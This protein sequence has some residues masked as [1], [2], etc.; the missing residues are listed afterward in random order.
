MTGP[1]QVGWGDALN[2]LNRPSEALTCY[3]QAVRLAPKE[4]AAAD[5]LARILLTRSASATDIPEAQ[6]LLLRTARQSPQVALTYLL[7]GQCYERQ[8]R[9]REARASLEEA[10]RRDPRLNEVHFEL[11]RVAQ[12]LGDAR[13]TAREQSLYQRRVTEDAQ[14]YALRLH[15]AQMKD[16]PGRTAGAGEA[17]VPE[18]AIGM[19]PFSSAARSSPNGPASSRLASN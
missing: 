19:R 9:W 12:N 13:T 1:T 5:S 4:P 17:F 15:V 14:I 10:G 2:A 7:L 16:D 11:G 8:S 3:R 18:T 6:G